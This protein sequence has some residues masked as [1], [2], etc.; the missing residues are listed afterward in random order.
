MREKKHLSRILI[1]LA[2]LNTIQNRRK[3]TYTNI[4]KRKQNKETKTENKTKPK[5]TQKN[6]KEMKR[7]DNEKERN[8]HKQTPRLNRD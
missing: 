6:E 1:Y 8:K 4:E 7:R 3:K 5:T 2:G